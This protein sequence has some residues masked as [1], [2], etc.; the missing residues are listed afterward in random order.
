MTIDLVA[1]GKAA[2][3]AA[4]ALATLNTQQKNAALLAIALAGATEAGMA[5]WLP[6]YS[7][8]VLGYSRAAGGMALAGLPLIT[9]GFWSKDEILAESWGLGFG[10][11][12]FGPAIFVFITLVLA[13]FLALN[14]A[15]RVPDMLTGYLGSRRSL[16]SRVALS[17]LVRG[18]STNSR[19][20]W[21]DKGE[22]GIGSGKAVT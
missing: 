12:G 2:K 9:A 18:C 16:T 10:G 13:A 20:N 7:E 4:R 1:M 6:A 15:R 14:I 22:N 19:F 5:Q 3:E 17:L 8:R 21:V 11:E